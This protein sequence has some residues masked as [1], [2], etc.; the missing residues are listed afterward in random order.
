MPRETH[1]VRIRALHVGVRRAVV[2]CRVRPRAVHQALHGVAGDGRDLPVLLL[3]ARRRERPR[4]FHLARARLGLHAAACGDIHVRHAQRAKVTH[5]VHVAVAHQL[6]LRQHAVV[7]AER[8]DGAD[9]CIRR[10]RGGA[11]TI[12]GRRSRTHRTKPKES[13][14]RRGRHDAVKERRRLGIIVQD[15]RRIVV[16]A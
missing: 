9:E 10:R 4:T 5:R 16:S 1:R 8:L 15:R 13:R 12:A 14:S 7:V 2:P 6:L 11:E 3:H